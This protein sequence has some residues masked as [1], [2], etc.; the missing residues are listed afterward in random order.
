MSGA[1]SGQLM[2]QVYRRQRHIYDLT[3]KYYLLG[4]D[5]LIDRLQADR[6]ACVLELGCGTGRNLIAA[7]RRYPDTR[8]FGLDISREMLETAEANIARAGLENQ[9]TLAHG[10]AANFDAHRL[11][12]EKV[13]DRVFLSYTVSMIPPWEEALRQGLACT[14]DGGRML[15]VDFGQQERL[16]RWFR[17]ILRSWLK[18]FHVTPRQD[19]ERDLR[20]LAT[21]SQSRLAFEPM[22]R[23]YTWYAE[24]SR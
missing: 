10:D 20:A 17:S 15:V 13:F 6:G 4:R 11:F 1:Q 8:L 14:A 12:G 5:H 7:A 18:M 22:Y 23:G 21:D 19:L 16:P 9:I 3:R 24:V 2:D